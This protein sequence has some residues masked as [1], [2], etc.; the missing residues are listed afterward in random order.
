MIDLN[1][2]KQS[3][4][5]IETRILFH[6]LLATELALLSPFKLPFQLAIWNSCSA[7][8]LASAILRA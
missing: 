6:L 2:V 8:V 3:I 1:S 4:Q 5:K 7:F